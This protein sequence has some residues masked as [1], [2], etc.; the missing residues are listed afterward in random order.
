MNDIVDLYLAKR[1]RAAVAAGHP[2]LYRR[3]LAKLPAAPAGSLARVSDADGFVAWGLYDPEHPIAVRVWSRVAAAIPGP[4]LVCARLERA[5][6]LRRRVLAPDVR[7]YRLLHGEAD[8][9][10]GWAVDVYEDVAVVRS[11]GAAAI[12]RLDWLSQA[13]MARADTWGL[14][15]L[16]HR[17]ARGDREG[18]RAELLWGQLPAQPQQVREGIWTMEADVL[19][20]QKTGWFVDQRD[21]RRLIFDLAR[22][23]CVAN[24]FS[25]T[26]GFSLAAAL[27]GAAHVTS[28]DISASAIQAAHRNFA[29]NG[30]DPG[31]YEFVVADAFAWLETAI[32]QRRR[33]DLIV[34]DPPSFAPNAQS[35]PRAL[36]AYGRL[37]A[38]ALALCE[39]GGLIALAS[40]SSHIGAADLCAQ[41]QTAAGAAGRELRLLAERG[42]GLDHPLLPAFPEGRYLKFLLFAVD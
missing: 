11:D 26:G 35:V 20:G 24:L 7:G 13:L 23:R 21:N 31:E 2:W 33:Y 36:G 19:E 39:V 8:G 3:A 30:L 10:P 6:A 34:I 28:I 29:A 1:L 37:F 32:A 16:V 27:G 40:C 22:G 25:Y 17:R 14:R 41:A 12:A 42:A 5:W 9:V 18:P 4:E 15:A 38:G